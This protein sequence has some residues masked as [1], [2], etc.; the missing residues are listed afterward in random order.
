MLTVILAALLGIVGIVA[1][2]VGMAPREGTARKEPAPAPATKPAVVPLFSW[3]E[4]AKNPVRLH[5]LADERRVVGWL[6]GADFTGQTV[7]VQAGDIDVTVPVT[8]ANT[9]L[10]DYAVKQPTRATFRLGDGLTFVHLAF[11][12]NAEGGNPLESVKA[13]QKF[14]EGI[15]ERC[16][17]A[18]QVAELTDVASY[19][20]S[21]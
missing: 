9:F 8:E 4:P 5:V 16:D 21:G 11:M 15:G 14:Q 7:R 20:F 13:F 17:V 12:N 18:P 10:W 2:L 6:S 19:G 3:S 1:V